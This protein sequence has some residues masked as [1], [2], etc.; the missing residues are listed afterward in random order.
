MDWRHLDASYKLLPLQGQNTTKALQCQA[1]N[2]KSLVRPYSLSNGR[3]M[4]KTKRP[5]PKK[6]KEAKK[7]PQK[8]ESKSRGKLLWEIL[9]AVCTLAGGFAFSPRVSVS[10]PSAQSQKNNVLS[11][12]FE[13]SNT[14][15]ISLGDIAIGVAPDFILSPGDNG[16]GLTAISSNDPSLKFLAH[17]TQ[18]HF[19]V[20]KS[21]HVRVW[22]IRPCCHWS[23]L[24]HVLWLLHRYRC[25][26]ER[27]ARVRRP[28]M[29]R[30]LSLSHLAIVSA[31]TRV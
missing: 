23:R 7:Q 31:S 24:H 9:L 4:S 16:G 1:F 6:Q 30:H 27:A 20:I 21:P 13:I 19:S 15:Y 28:I 26:H 29:Q 3:Q 14:G 10:A 5:I 18:Q 2:L 8:P 12:S 22:T 17:S 25:S 11:A